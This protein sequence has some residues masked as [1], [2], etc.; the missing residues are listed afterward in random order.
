MPNTGVQKSHK[1][2]KN[3]KHQIFES[4]FFGLGQ[5]DVG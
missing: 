2:N 3:I 1:G 4:H 5:N